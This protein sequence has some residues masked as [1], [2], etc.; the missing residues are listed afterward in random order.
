[1]YGER[2]NDAQRVRKRF[3]FVGGTIPQSTQLTYFLCEMALTL[4][5][6]VELSWF[7][8]L[9][10]AVGKANFCKADDVTLENLP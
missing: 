8:Q 3:D 7:A 9:V 6:L 2:P 1:M 10:N 5:A 4:A